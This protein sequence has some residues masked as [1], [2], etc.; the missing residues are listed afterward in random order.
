MA[1]PVTVAGVA[2]AD[3]RT[4]IERI[5]DAPKQEDDSMLSDAQFS[6]LKELLTTLLTPGYEC[7]KLMLPQLQAEAARREAWERREKQSK[8]PPDAAA[9]GAPKQE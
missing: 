5:N 8:M 7:S 3:R 6:E 2:Q 4:H 1:D 9:E